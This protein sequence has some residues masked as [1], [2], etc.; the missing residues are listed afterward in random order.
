M[1]L[2]QHWSYVD[3]VSGASFGKPYPTYRYFQYRPKSIQK[4]YTAPSSLST[5]WRHMDELALVQ[6]VLDAAHRRL[7]SMIPASAEPYERD[8]HHLMQ[9][10]WNQWS[11]TSRHLTP[12]MR[13]RQAQL[14]VAGAILTAAEPDDDAAEIP[15]DCRGGCHRFRGTRA[16]RSN[17]E[18]WGGDGVAQADSACSV[19]G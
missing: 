4:P 12:A 1:Q 17:F 8:D 18:G 10:Q 15:I 9:G 3:F 5:E 6:R 13:W 16:R 14:C 19:A 7:H 2:R 11:R